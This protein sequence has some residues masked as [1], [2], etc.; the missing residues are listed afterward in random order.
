MSDRNLATL[1]S[2]LERLLSSIA[3]T[4]APALLSSPSA[5]SIL[6]SLSFLVA[7]KY[8]S[9]VGGALTG[10]PDFSSFQ[11]DTLCP[12]VPLSLKI[13]AHTLQ[14][15]QIVIFWRFCSHMWAS[16]SGQPQSFNPHRPKYQSCSDFCNEDHHPQPIFRA[17]QQVLLH[18]QP[19]HKVL[20]FSFRI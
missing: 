2:L 1:L 5:F 3:G 4:G 11:H 14:A 18:L 16:L 7:A 6:R 9:A 20:N 15:P 8:Q 10:L 13:C 19:C 12:A 17:Q